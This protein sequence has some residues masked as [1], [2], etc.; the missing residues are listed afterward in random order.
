MNPSRNYCL[1]VLIVAL[2][3]TALIYWPGLAGSFTFDDT[4]FVTGNSA[5]QVSSLHLAD[6]V[7]AAMSFP[8]NHQGR[9]LTMLSFAA[10]HYFTGMDPYWYKLTNLVIHLLN[11]VLLYLA[12]RALFH[13][14][15]KSR[16][17]SNPSF[18][19]GLAAATLAALWLVLPINLT[20]VLYVSQRLE[21]LSNTFVFL[22]LAWYLR[23]RLALWQEQG[24]GTGLWLALITCTGIGVLVKESAVL[25]PLYAFSAELALTGFRAR[26]GRW[27][28]PVLA[29][30]GTLLLIPLMTGLVW[31]AG[32][33][34]GPNSYGRAFDIPQR[35]MTEGRVLM[36]YM[37]WTLV[38]SLD[39]LTLYHDDIQVSRSLL[40]PPAT[41]ASVTA[42][43]GLIAFALWKRSQY[44]LLALGIFWYFGGHLLTATIIPLMLAFE[45]RNYFPSAGLLL[46]MASLLALEFRILRQRR[47]I[48]V[49]SFS[50]F[51]FYAFTTALRAREWS[52][53]L[54]LAASDAAKRPD[55]SA[56][57]YEYARVLLGSTLNG[58]P[59]PMRRKAF[60]VLENMAANPDADAVHNQLLIVTSAKLGLPINDMWWESMI[61]KLKAHPV[62]S[63][64]VSALT[65][66]LT[67]VE[68]KVC[69]R[70]IDH[71]RR[72]Y[73]AASSHP[74]GYA[75]LLSGYAKFA[76]VYLGD[77][78]LAGK[79][80][81][82]AVDR[83]PSHS[84]P[85]ANLVM[86]LIRT[87]EFEQAEIA[88]EDLR[89]LNYL[90]RLDAEIAD[91]QR[92]LDV[93]R[94]GGMEPV[95][96][97]QTETN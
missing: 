16:S 37:A 52:S 75:Q 94:S 23:A 65:A 36:H 35:L 45:H 7:N 72:A 44:P 4:G 73:E 21:S 53:P 82:D 90:N 40:D 59:E 76:L 29:L 86:F 27:S 15:Q 38:P 6:W 33:V 1:P 18:N 19:G 22:G 91:L 49:A 48:A 77:L 83:S 56:A 9:W 10:N 66:L 84:V 32:W 55:S 97:A 67:C 61:A 13:F 41:L 71:L 42:I 14:H 74:G 20:G 79:L 62:T 12:L 51:A 25:L 2:A 81:R 50:L 89:K 54:A 87:G 64:D 95:L 24:K 85:R 68:R 47:W 3:L 17:D 46:A 5:I 96:P 57:Q 28:R 8:A 80:Y 93:A 92:S 58:D 43:A 31:L 30:Y 78:D 39:S 88:L 11:G 69:P 26:D 60:A 70:D 63:I 34:G